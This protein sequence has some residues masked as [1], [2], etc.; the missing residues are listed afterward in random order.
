MIT[1][2]CQHR[3]EETGHK[4]GRVYLTIQNGCLVIICTH[5][6]ERH[7]NTITLSDMVR[8]QEE[9]KR[10]REPALQIAQ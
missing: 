8:L 9:D 6:G 1:L 5:D 10:R 4:C 3:D 2:H 7:V